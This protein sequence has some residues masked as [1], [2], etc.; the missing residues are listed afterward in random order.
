MLCLLQPLTSSHPSH[1][2]LLYPSN[3]PWSRSYANTSSSLIRHPDFHKPTVLSAP[4]FHLHQRR[5]HFEASCLPQGPQ[6]FPDIWNE[7][8]SITSEIQ[9]ASPPRWWCNDY[10][11]QPRHL[12]SAHICFYAL[13][14]EQ[15][16]QVVH[17]EWFQTIQEM[18]YQDVATPMHQIPRPR[19]WR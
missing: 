5:Q 19:W 11:S 8:Q 16:H 7:D 2:I 10:Q 12:G 14:Q 6:G 17:G 13:V 3:H 4:D 15:T 18:Q 9:H 1:P